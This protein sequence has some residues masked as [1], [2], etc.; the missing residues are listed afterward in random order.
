[1]RQQLLGSELTV[2]QSETI[3]V[4]AFTIPANGSRQHLEIHNVG[5]VDMIIN[6][7]NADATEASFVLGAGLKYLPINIWGN[8]IELTTASSTTTAFIIES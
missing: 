4:S 5:A 8:A 6:I 7:I 2:A 1:M 3:S